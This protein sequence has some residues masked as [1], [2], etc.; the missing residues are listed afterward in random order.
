MVLD[1]I[2][3]RH[4]GRDRL[5]GLIWVIRQGEQWAVVGPAGSGKSL[6]AAAVAG[7]ALV[8]K[9][10]VSHP[11]V[12]KLT[13]ARFP[14]ARLGYFSPRT[15]H[16]LASRSSSF[17]QSRWHG[18]LD[19]GDTTVEQYLSWENLHDINPYEVHPGLAQPARYAAQC[20]GILKQLGLSDVWHRRVASLSHGELRKVVLAG[21]AL[22]KPVLLVLDEPLEAL[23]PQSRK[24]CMR[25]FSRLCYKGVTLVWVTH[26]LEEL[27]SFITHVLRLGKDRVVAMGSRK[28]VLHEI[29]ND[30]AARSCSDT[31]TRLRC[32]PEVRHTQAAPLVELH[33]VSIRAGRQWILRNIDWTIREGERWLL[34]GHNGSGKSTLLNVIQGDHPQVYAQAVTLFGHNSAR[35]GDYWRARRGLGWMSPELSFHYPAQFTCLEVVC[36]GFYQSTGLFQRPSAQRRRRALTALKRMGLA[37]IADQP[38]GCVSLAQQRMVLILR[39][40]IHQPRLLLLDEPCQGMDAAQRRKVI[41]WVDRL[42]ARRSTGLVYVSHFRED[43]PQCLTHE[44]L[45][46]KGQVIK[47]R[48]L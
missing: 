27:P 9:G 10:E 38:L 8:V 25:F 21:T 26:R 17:Y 28:D 3:V 30:A 48:P 34:H 2:T 15:Q 31:R 5:K 11:L 45:L 40:V 44:L 46:R 33:K 7:Q 24:D 39:A 35:P 18:S 36:S 47:K 29:E 32:V 42:M 4:A 37:S 23:D 22:K 13:D 16:Q 1:R 12:E 20:R 41:E 43:L 6:L 19:D 14:G